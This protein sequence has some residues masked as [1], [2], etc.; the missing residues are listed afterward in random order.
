MIDNPQITQIELTNVLGVSKRTV[1]RMIEKLVSE[2]KVVRVG[3]KRSGY[4]KVIKKDLCV[5]IIV[6]YIKNV[7]GY[8]IF[9][10]NSIYLLHR[11]LLLI[12]RILLRLGIEIY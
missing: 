8:H 2:A 1:Q 4:W 3:S 10:A 7:L 9:I 11:L 6:N 5:E 12:N